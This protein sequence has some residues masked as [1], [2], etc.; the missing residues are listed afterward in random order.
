[1]L[2]KANN[3]IKTKFDSVLLANLKHAQIT[4]LKVLPHVTPHSLAVLLLCR[5]GLA[6][7]VQM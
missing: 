4:N 5:C 2:N 7:K 6:Q 1:M 3:H